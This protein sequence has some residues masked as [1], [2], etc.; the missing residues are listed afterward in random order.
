MAKK[1]NPKFIDKD[2]DKLRALQ[3]SILG[4]IVDTYCRKTSLSSKKA[5]EQD[6]ITRKDSTDLSSSSKTA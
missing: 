5:T 4:E 1:A 6:C 2:P 3:N